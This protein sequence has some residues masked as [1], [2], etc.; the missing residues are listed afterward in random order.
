MC[1][2]AERPPAPDE[3]SRD[4]GTELAL[5]I[6]SGDA[7]AVRQ[8]RERVRKIIG[9]KHLRI[10]DDQLDDLEQEIVTQIWQA[11]NQ[12]SFEPSR[13][14]WGFVE[15]VTT[16]RCIDWLRTRRPRAPLSE[17]IRDEGPGPLRKTLRQERSRLVS[18]VL[19]SL[20][21]P[22]RALISLRLEEGLS[23]R[24]LSRRLGKSEGALRVQMYRCV[25]RAG[26]LLQSLADREPER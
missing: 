20:G 13:G 18:S 1:S 22:C 12:R 21:P 15:L 6:R 7:E 19:E 4:R 26:A 17:T 5:R 25:Q 11:V 16:R 23:Y 10:P 24:E 2:E 9:F 14:F 3:R 8:V